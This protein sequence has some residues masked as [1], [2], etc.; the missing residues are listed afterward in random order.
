MSEK[1]EKS[2]EKQEQSY[3][4]Y[5]DSDLIFEITKKN[6]RA[7][8]EFF[9]RYA[10]KVK[11]LMLKVGA[12]DLD[13]EEISQEVMAILW[14][15]SYLYDSNKSAVSSWVYTIAR[16]YRIDFLRKGSRL[17]LDSDDPTFVPD[18]PLNS[19]QILINLEKKNRVK[20]VLRN[21]SLEKK[22]L[23]TAAFF[24]G[25]SHSELAF[26]FG[27]PLGTI[28]SRLRLIYDSLRNAEDLKPL[29]GS[30]ES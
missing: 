12:K 2:K 13:A 28:K 7:F 27:K 18:P 3:T 24:E 8:E 19:V 10:N 11:F 30:D 21:L 22:Q 29:S 15:K 25:L 14:R 26:K 17:I 20:K 1:K 9:K 5:E 6:N 16:N 4:S 23:L